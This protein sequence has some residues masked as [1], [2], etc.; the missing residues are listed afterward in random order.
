MKKSD[1]I[2]SIIKKR[3]IPSLNRI[4]SDNM[5]SVIVYG[6]VARD[7]Y[8][9]KYSDINILIL[10]KK[11]DPTAVISFGKTLFR[12]IRKYRLTPLILTEK[13]FVNS[14]DVFPME[15]NDIKDNYIIVTGADPVPSLKLT[16]TSLR[17]Q[18]EYTV[19]GIINQLRQG[20]I[21]SR[22]RKKVSYMLL[23]KM[24]GSIE[25]VLRSSLRLKNIDISKLD[26]NAVWEK[27]IEIYGLREI[28]ASEFINPEKENISE[29]VSALL[30]FLTELTTKID[31]MEI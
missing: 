21:A 31:S 27:T 29:T 19:R 6:S 2:N 10:L 28:N 5:T 11:S 18:T 7:N 25:S 30:L 3:I 23:K 15:Y 9:Q 1:V 16:D 14:A 17:H 20:L 26:R 24:T 4:F 12:D 8:D 13:E 22:G